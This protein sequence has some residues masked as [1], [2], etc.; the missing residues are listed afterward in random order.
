MKKRDLAQWGEIDGWA[1]EIIR[2]EGGMLFVLRRGTFCIW[3]VKGKDTRL[4]G[5]ISC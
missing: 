5:G 3:G 2:G 4:E 1:G